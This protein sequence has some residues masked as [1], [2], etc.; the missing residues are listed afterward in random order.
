MCANIVIGACEVAELS[1]VGYRGPWVCDNGL[2]G[3][4]VFCRVYLCMLLYMCVY[5]VG[6]EILSGWLRT[7]VQG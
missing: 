3:V 5:M 1:T 4:C 6:T 7:E 2:C